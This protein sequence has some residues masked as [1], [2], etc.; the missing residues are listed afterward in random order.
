[1]P[2]PA[3]RDHPGDGLNA[4][5]PT[6]RLIDEWMI[7]EEAGNSLLVS[8]TDPPEAKVADLA[9]WMTAQ[10]RTSKSPPSN[11]S[12]YNPLMQVK[13]NE[14]LAFHPGNITLGSVRR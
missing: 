14:S 11:M 4:L 1:M 3:A 7:S 13:V 12:Y 2:N 9:A 6:S 5:R 10:K 8:T